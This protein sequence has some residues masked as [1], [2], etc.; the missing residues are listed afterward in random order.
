MALV[1]GMPLASSAFTFVCLPLNS[2]FQ[3]AIDAREFQEGM[4]NY[5]VGYI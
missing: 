2:R 3:L 4:L 1:L 5:G